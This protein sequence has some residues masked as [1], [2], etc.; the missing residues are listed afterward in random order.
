MSSGEE[1]KGP[2]FTIVDRRG[3]EAEAAEQQPEGPAQRAPLPPVDFPGFLLSLA[4]SALFHLGLVADPKTGKTASPDLPVARQTI[5]TLELLERKT[6]G[7]LT[8]EEAELLTK[9][10]TELRLRF[11]EVS[12][13]S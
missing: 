12:Q 2:G 8:A 6:R 3:Q 9:L 13:A 7:N 11:V 5:D 1:S 10:L 4:T